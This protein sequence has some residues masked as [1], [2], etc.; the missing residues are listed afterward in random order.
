V[1]LD[2]AARDRDTVA[3]QLAPPLL[4]AVHLFASTGATVAVVR[5]GPGLIAQRVA[6]MIVAVGY[7]M[8]DKGVSTAAD[9]EAGR[10]LAL[11]IR[12]GA[13]VNT[14]DLGAASARGVYVAN[15]PG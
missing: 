7:A 12:A 13:G 15:C 14:I 3:L 11:V 4:G 1:P 10:T 6:A 2:R 8:L 5:D 9:I